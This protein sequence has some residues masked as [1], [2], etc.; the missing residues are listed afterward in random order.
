[1][2]SP[3]Q[4]SLTYK[5]LIELIIKSSDVHE[6]RWMLSIG[7]GF[8]PGNFG[9]TPD[10][11]SPGVVVAINQ[12]SIVRE[13]PEASAP[14]GLVVDAAVVNPAPKVAGQVAQPRR[15]VSRKGSLA[16]K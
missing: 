15:K 8:A 10:Q 14:V 3:T 16:H 2:A 11:M 6:G 9:P 1:M 4:Y 7:F 12:I 13:Q 5:E